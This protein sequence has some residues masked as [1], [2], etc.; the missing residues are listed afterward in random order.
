[1]AV[2][3]W[4]SSRPPSSADSL[5]CRFQTR[6]PPSGKGSTSVR[7]SS[8]MAPDQTAVLLSCSSSSG[9]PVF[10]F[11]RANRNWSSIAARKRPSFEN[12]IGVQNFRTGSEARTPCANCA[13]KSRSPSSLRPT[14]LSESRPWWTNG[15]VVQGIAHHQP[16]GIFCIRCCA[17]P[18]ASSDSPIQVVR[19][20][21]GTD[22]F[23][24]RNNR[25]PCPGLPPRI[26][27]LGCSR[28]RLAG[29]RRSG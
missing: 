26:R 3:R 28:R 25:D 16:R 22:L 18:P 27:K 2:Q 13:R 10:R 9:S 23:L 17:C 21:R 14:T 6:S 1:M 8:L 29:S 4:R 7:K 24:R 20:Q 19:F 5:D 12:L 15:R 11:S